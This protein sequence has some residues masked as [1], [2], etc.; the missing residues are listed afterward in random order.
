MSHVNG[1]VVVEETGTGV[2]NLVVSAFDAQ[3][4]LNL[5]EVVSARDVITAAHL[6]GRGAEG[7]GSTATRADGSFSIVCPAAEA[8]ARTARRLLL[9]VATPES[10]SNSGGL[11]LYVTLRPS[12]SE[13]ETFVI[14]LKEDLLK[15]AGVLRPFHTAGADAIVTSAELAVR[16]RQRIR[17]DL[18]TAAAESLELARDERKQYKAFEKIFVESISRLPE[19]KIHGDLLVRDGDSVEAINK[20]AISEGLEK[21]INVGKIKTRYYL[22]EAQR[23]ALGDLSPGTQISFKEFRRILM[24]LGSDTEPATPQLIHQNEIIF[25]CLNKIRDEF[26]ADILLS[27]GETRT[28]PADPRGSG[29]GRRVVEGRG[30]EVTITDGI[31]VFAAHLMDTAKPPEE[32]LGLNGRRPT[33]EDVQNNVGGFILNPGPADQPSFFDF[34]T[35]QIAFDHVWQELISEDVLAE[36][37]VVH[38]RLRDLGGNPGAQEH[39]RKTAL[40]ALRDEAAAVESTLRRKEN[41]TITL[42]PITLTLKE[43]Q[44]FVNNMISGGVY[45]PLPSTN[46]PPTSDPSDSGFSL[47]SLGGGG[48]VGAPP[49]DDPGEDNLLTRL[50]NLLN[51][52]YAFTIFGANDK[53]RSINF[54]IVATFRQ[55]WAPVA[56]QAGQLVKTIPMAPKQTQKIVISK[57]KKKTVARNQVDKA[58]SMRRQE[59]SETSRA[60]DEIVKKARAK[61]NFNL[62]SDGTY[63]F[64]I[65]EGSAETTIGRDAEDDSA[66]TKKDFREAVFKA[67]QE[68]KN[69]NILE[70][71]EETTL[72]EEETITSEISN[73]NEELACTF[74]FYELQRRYRMHEELHRITPVVLVAQEVPTYDRITDAWLIAHDWVLKRTL[75]DDSFRPALDYLAT[76]YFGDEKALIHLGQDLMLH[77][78]L[79]ED[80][81]REVLSLEK[82]K[83]TAYDQ[84]QHSI[85]ELAEQVRNESKDGAWNDIKD[86]FGGGGEAPEAARVIEQGARDA[87]EKAAAEAKDMT[88]RLEREVAAL[89]A[90]SERYQKVLQDY[91]NWKIQIERLK[92]HVKDNI[93]YYMQGIWTHEV[94]DQRYF[95]LFQVK[96]PTFEHIEGENGGT[97]YTVI[98]TSD[99]KIV[100]STDNDEVEEASAVDFEITPQLRVRFDEANLKSLVEVAD[101]DKLLGFKGNYAIFPLRQSNPLTDILMDPYVNTAFGQILGL[102]DPDEAG[103]M[104]RHDFAKFVV[105]LHEALGDEEFDKIKD[106]LKSQY[107]RILLTANRPGEEIIVPSGSLFIELLPGKHAL[108]EDFKLLHRQIDVRKAMAA[109]RHDE[110]EN[111]R[112]A[113]RLLESK[114]HIE[115]LEDAEIEKKVII[116]GNTENVIVPPGDDR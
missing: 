84:L 44:L 101:L 79:V 31:P 14:Q 115:L 52:P 69:E 38:Y 37:E 34:H 88:M 32:S 65:A 80:L 105:C 46:P 56:Y 53:E 83:D 96:V 33:Q 1:R 85:Q 110:L 45:A 11:L 94:P 20:R 86:F 50:T 102:F 49:K 23:E 25:K 97:S 18:T 58:S 63:N 109:T 6:L 5:A 66:E 24:G 59:S 90:A 35:L 73:P 8:I 70:V 19:K 3:I 28:D 104:S 95:R 7:L 112:L 74:L 60:E 81:K 61:T 68:Y 106:A 67:A 100:V 78:R 13:Y 17:R 64:G 15:K 116:E 113:A 89:Q 57:K 107:K 92:L 91:N 82:K 12:A 99:D 55:E 111:L 9:I 27:N 21:R 77:R 51:T 16:D 103:N 87:F 93:L 47:G 4:E 72:E 2:A 30:S 40:Q 75:L 41:P 39:E 114:E 62:Q 42:N 48:Q 76:R 26:A 36:T 54:G 98:D 29:D 108:L 22:T 71:K 43:P 10:P